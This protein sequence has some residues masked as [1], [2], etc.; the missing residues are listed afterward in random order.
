MS[1]NVSRPLLQKL[2]SA[3]GI[4]I[5]KGKGWKLKSELRSEILRT[6]ADSGNSLHENWIQRVE[7]GRNPWNI[8]FDPLHKYKLPQIQEI[9]IKFF[10][11]IQIGDKSIAKLRQELIEKQRELKY[12]ESHYENKENFPEPLTKYR[13]STS[14]NKKFRNCKFP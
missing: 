7:K 9:A 10:F 1:L 13:P 12:Q 11:G 5:T 6:V 4:T 14:F 3:L 8:N 2:A